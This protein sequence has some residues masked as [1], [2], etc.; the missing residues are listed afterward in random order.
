MSHDPQTP[1]DDV[2]LDLAPPLPLQPKL[3][4]LDETALL[5]VSNSTSLND[6][7][8][9]WKHVAGP[10]VALRANSYLV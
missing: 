7:K 5:R 9:S 4:L 8:V 6:L 1:S 2:I 10:P 3:A